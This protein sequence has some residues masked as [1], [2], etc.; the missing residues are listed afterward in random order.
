MTETTELI[1][2][3]SEEDLPEEVRG[4]SELVREAGA[5]LRAATHRPHVKRMHAVYTLFIAV[6]T[7]EGQK[8]GASISNVPIDTLLAM[9]RAQLAGVEELKASGHELDGL[10]VSH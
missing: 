9:L 7:N 8:I 2:L 6:Q 1:D 10:P 5:A 4:F 3:P